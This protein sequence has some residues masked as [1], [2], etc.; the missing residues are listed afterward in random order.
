[1]TGRGP[2]AVGSRGGQRPLHQTRELRNTSRP[3]ALLLLGAEW[4]R[5]MDSTILERQA[6]TAS[7][8]GA[9]VD[10]EDFFENG[11]VCLHLVDGSGTILRANKAELDL[12]GYTAEEY[13][14]RP[15]TD[16]HVDAAVIGD[17][18]HQLSSGERLD[19]YPARLRAKDGSI[20]HVLVSS[21][22]LFRDGEFIN[23]RCFSVDVTATREAEAARQEAER[24]LATTYDSVTV[25]IGETDAAGRFL[26]VNAAFEAITGYPPDELLGMT[27][28]QF[29]HADDR[30]EDVALYMDQVAG[31]QDTYAI[32]KRYVRKDGAEVFVEV[33]SSTVRNADGSFGYGVRVVKDVS[34]RK[35]AELHLQ[36]SER[37]S[38]ELLDAL[39]IAVYTTDPAGR[40]TYYNEAAVAFSGR[41]PVL[42]M[43][44]WCVTWKLFWPDGT[45]LPHN[46]CPMALALKDGVETRG[47]EAIAERPDG[48]RRTF[49]PYPTVLR[50]SSGSMI[51]AINVLVD[52]TDR[53]QADEEQKI[54]IDELNHR[55]KN[56]LATVQS[57]SLHTYRSTPDAFV[58]RFE[59]RLVALSKAHDLLTR[60][61]WAGLG[62]GEL[63]EQEFGPYSDQDDARIVLV[64]PELTLSTRAALAL[65]MVLHELVTNA[66]KYGALSIEGG[67]VRVGWSI[68][69]SD[70]GNSLALRWSE[71]GGPAVEIPTRRGFG[72]RLIE[73]TITKDL[74]GRADLQ[75]NPGGLQ[76]FISFPL[77]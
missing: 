20:K 77:V 68:E 29:T 9:A 36:E 65:S 52:V 25:G 3:K 17:I 18:L 72:R 30:G 14:G 35:R 53:K 1:M 12:L 57:I 37:R 2:E 32:E 50:D 13:V 48:S 33:L 27:F 69:L 76:C 55:V 19:K 26:H 46:E 23:S 39:P 5:V 63:M 6:A 24:R 70:T 10:F 54:L 49:N 47:V 66:A 4:A 43:D 38:R 51:G 62:L 8:G 31:L 40:I 28:D 61:R 56:T 71:R 41:R 15:I 21:S 42:G 58:E 22:V 73:R 11:A 34:D 7:P 60:R 64:G 45:P 74:A 67:K 44:E 75:F 59:D 16:F